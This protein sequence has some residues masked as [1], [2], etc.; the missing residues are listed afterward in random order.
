M[1]YVG[2]TGWFISL[3]F[4][5]EG[6]IIGLLSGTIAYFLQE[7]MYKRVVAMLTSEFNVIALT[8]FSS[9]S[10]YVLLGFLV[11]GVFTGIVGS[12]ISLRKYMKA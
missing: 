3:P 8:P 9:L 4:V 10:R 6:T 7:F 2:A 11:T 5:F 12:C 1:R